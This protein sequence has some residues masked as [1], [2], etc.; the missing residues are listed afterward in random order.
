[1]EVIEANIV[2]FIV[3]LLLLGGA[4]KGYKKGLVKEL[5]S[6]IGLIMALMA[7]VFIV[8][9]VQGY[10]QQNT[11][12]MIVSGICFVVVILA[13][14]IIDFILESLNLVS[15]LP[16]LGGVNKLAG[17]AAGAAEGV[18]IVWILFLILTT[19][20][21]WG[22]GEYITASIKGDQI[23]GF[24]FYNKYIMELMSQLPK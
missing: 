13:Y 22:L 21:F 1:M 4:I 17:I 20:N 19:F 14:K 16:L 3:Q 2:L 15:K 8:G 7:V 5:S 6:F 12:Q 18:I 11:R 24:L 23:L 10:Q 9:A